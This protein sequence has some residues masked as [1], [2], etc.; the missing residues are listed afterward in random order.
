M[1]VDNRI[2][3]MMEMTLCLKLKVKE[4]PEQLA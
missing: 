3:I 4:S 2:P 1:S